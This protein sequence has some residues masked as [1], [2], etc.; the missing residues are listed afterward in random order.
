MNVLVQ[1]RTVLEQGSYPH[2]L[3]PNSEYQSIPFQIDEPAILNVVIIPLKGPY[4]SADGI[5]FLLKPGD[6]LIVTTDQNQKPILTHK[7][8]PTRTKELAFTKNYM[9]FVGKTLPYTLFGSKGNAALSRRLWSNDL[10]T[11]DRLLDSLYRPYI[12]K[13]ESF[14][15][16]NGID[17]AIGKWFKNFYWGSMVYDKLFVDHEISDIVKKSLPV[18]YRDSLSAWSK[19]ATCQDCNNIP[20]FK[21]AIEKIS[22]MRFGQRGEVEYMD[23]V[24]NQ[25]TGNIRDFLLSR[26]MLNRME[27]TSDPAKLL[28]HYDKLCENKIYKTLIHDSYEFHAQQSKVTKDELATL[29]RADKSEIGFTQLLR[30]LKG[31]VIYIDFWASWCGPCIAEFP[32]SHQL[33]E[34]IRDQKIVMM[35]LSVDTDFNSWNKAREKHKVNTKY[36]FILADPAKNELVKKIALGPIPRYMIIDTN[37]NIVRMDAARPSDPETSNTLLEVLKKN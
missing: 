13:A 30:E 3:E 27:L 6:S 4:G 9:A 5:Y 37:G 22:T 28:A 18:F 31:N 21:N 33:N 10:K 2:T 24:A 11:R 14:C 23:A 1:K 20:P 25:T 36:S 12:N 32:A 16:A 8:N 7:F 35:Y 29:I 17:P 15:I 19:N 26:H 34:K